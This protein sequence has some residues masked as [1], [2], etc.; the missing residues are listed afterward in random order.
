MS[1][2]T[3]DVEIP[4]RQTSLSLTRASNSNR[5]LDHRQSNV[6]QDHFQSIPQRC[7]AVI[8]ESK[9]LLRPR[10]AKFTAP[11]IKPIHSI[12]IETWANVVHTGERRD[13]VESESFPSS[14]HRFEVSFQRVRNGQTSGQPRQLECL[15]SAARLFG[16]DKKVEANRSS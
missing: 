13:R 8:T 3:I 12:E 6:T 9:G 14:S 16:G 10:L 2:T 1:K 11:Q 5:T 7:Q 4:A 15:W